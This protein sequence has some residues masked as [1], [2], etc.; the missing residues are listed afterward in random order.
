MQGVRFADIFGSRFA[1]AFE[2]IRET[3]YA[4]RLTPTQQ[5]IG[6]IAQHLEDAIVSRAQPA[7]YW[8]SQIT[9]TLIIPRVSGLLPNG[10]AI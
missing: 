7:R 5:T 8:R 4:C 9:S 6:N 10:T 2:S 3:R 1:A